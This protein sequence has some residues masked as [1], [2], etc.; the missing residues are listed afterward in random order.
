VTAPAL[1]IDR[2]EVVFHTARQD[3]FA[4]REVSLRVEPGEVV[5][6]VGESGSGKSVAMMS[7]MRLL[8]PKTSSISAGKLTVEGR[9][10]LSLSRRDIEDL[11]GRVVSYV[12]QD[13]LTALNPVLTVGRQLAEVLRRHRGFSHEE[14]RAGAIELLAEVGISDPER[15]VRDYPHQF[16]GGMR[17]RAMIAMALAARPHLLIADEPTTALD[18]TVQAEIVNLV[19]RLQ[20]AE[21][22]T[23]IWV[24][25]DLALLA[26]I[27]RRVVVMYAGRIVEDSPADILYEAPAHPYTAGL[28][29]STSRIDKPFGSQAAIA[30][31]PPDPYAEITACA[32]L[33]RCPRAGERC[34]K[35][36]PPLADV[37]AGRKAA[38]F[39]PLP[40]GVA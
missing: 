7:V 31:S 25:H 14:A 21:G 4:V 11:R 22:M 36:I 17:Q 27:A 8:D 2:L 40:A 26:R 23:M 3:L 30:G 12:F 15:R 28:L 24:T 10:I 16:S 34:A 13:A 32:F 39:H 38:C 9:D 37:G 6:L 29:A 5:G 19:Q 33:P 1:E 18:V 35:E 20:A